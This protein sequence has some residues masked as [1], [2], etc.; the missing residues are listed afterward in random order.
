MTC[1]YIAG[2]AL[3]LLGLILNTQQSYGMALMVEIIAIA[4]L[5]NVWREV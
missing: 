1:R 4:L 5:W 2:G 3:I